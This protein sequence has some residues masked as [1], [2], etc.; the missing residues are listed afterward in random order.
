MRYK[1][2]NIRFYYSVM[3]VIFIVGTVLESLALLCLVIGFISTGKSLKNVQPI[4]SILLESGNRATKSAYFNIVEAPV[5][6]GTEKKCNYYLLTDGNK[7]LVAEI[8]DDEYDEIKSA[9]EASGSYHVEGITHYIYDKK[10]RSEFAL[11][12]ERFTGQDVIA[13]SLDE[14]RGIL[15]IEYMKMNF[16]NVY[17]SGWG[18]AGIIIGIIGLPIFFGGRFEIKASRKVISLSN[19]TANDIDDEANKEGS[20]WLDSL[21]IYI[22][23]NMVLGIIS[24]GNKHEGQVALRYNEIQR[25]YG[26]NKVPEGLSPY[27]EGYYIIEAIATDGNKYTL[28]DTKLLFSAEDAVAETDELIMQIKKRNPNVQYGPENVKYLTYRFSYI[29]VDLEGEDALSET[30]KDNDKPDII[31][32]FNQTYLPLNFKPSDAIVSMNMNFPEDGIVEITTGYFGDRE[33]EVEHKLYDF[34]KGQLMDGWGEGYEYGNYVV[35][36]KEL[37]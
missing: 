9:V 27:R 22:T 33:N 11:E 10:K 6:L 25:I 18:L 12:A 24:D 23:E 37:V 21:R 1:N 3:Y 36:F 31:M 15:Y 13:E 2:K 34:L 16:W 7:Y 4:D 20:I 32:D 29:L 17:K 5:F 28:S 26:Y 8:D 30:I 14:E 19:I 35:S